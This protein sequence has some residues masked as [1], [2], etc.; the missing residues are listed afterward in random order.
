LLS[1][2]VPVALTVCP[3]SHPPL[4]RRATHPSR[5]ANTVTLTFVV[6][7]S[8]PLPAVPVLNVKVYSYLLH[9]IA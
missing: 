5:P 7:W 4:K 2:I 3:S 9:W 8:E 6:V 1:M